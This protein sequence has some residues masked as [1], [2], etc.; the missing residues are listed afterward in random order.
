MVE[1]GIWEVAKS[2]LQYIIFPVVAGFAYF[3]KKYIKRVEMSEERISLLSV[4]LSVV[5]SKIDDIREDLKEIK[6]GVEK[7]VDRK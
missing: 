6:R 2:T 3:L 4:R 7:L 5:E 1:L